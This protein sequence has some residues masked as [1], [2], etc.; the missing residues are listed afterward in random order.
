M[1]D[2]TP[3]YRSCGSKQT[4]KV[5]TKTA[6]KRRRVITV[7]ASLEQS[8]LELLSE[9]FPIRPLARCPMNAYMR[10]PTRKVAIA[11][12]IGCRYCFQS[13]YESGIPLCSFLW[14]CHPFGRF[15]CPCLCPFDVHGRL[16]RVL[17]RL[18]LIQ[19][20]SVHREFVLGAS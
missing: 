14:L 1:S 10:L 15:L 4:E 2:D 18:S 12:R 7:S 17:T 13:D 11:G 9:D 8:S 19:S 20:P 5:R 6:S 16:R 3:T